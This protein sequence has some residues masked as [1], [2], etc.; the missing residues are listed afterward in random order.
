MN[1][2]RYSELHKTIFIFTEGESEEVYLNRLKRRGTEYRVNIK[3]M[4]ERDL[5][6]MVV[7]SHT[8]ARHSGL[9]D[10]DEVY[11][12]FDVDVYNIEDLEKAEYKASNLGVILIASN[13]CFETWLLYHFIENV[14][15]SA[16]EDCAERLSE[17][18]GR[19]YRK[20]EGIGVVDLPT[21]QKAM[22]RSRRAYKC[23]NL[24]DI[25]NNPGCT[26]MHI[27]VDRLMRND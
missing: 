11:V 10:G 2:H 16:S 17:C 24:S 21:L 19:K 22:D 8:S 27:L 4:N 9:S 3:K 5:T 25:K 23:A 12:V 13:P 26:S 20:S 15:L 6:D 7:R 14:R 18:L 1:K